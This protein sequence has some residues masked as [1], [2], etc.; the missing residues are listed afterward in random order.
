MLAHFRVVLD[1]QDRSAA[2]AVCVVR[3]P[4]RT[5]VRRRSTAVGVSGTSI[6]KT[7]P[8]PA[9]SAPGSDVQAFAQALDY[10]G[11]RPRP[12]LSWRAVLSTNGTSKIG[13]SS[14]CGMPIRCPDPIRNL[15][16]RWHPTRSLPRWGYFS[17]S[18]SDCGA[19]ARADADRSELTARRG[20]S[21]ARGRPRARENSILPSDGRTA[22]SSACRRFQA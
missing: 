22:H 2:G 5:V 14:D 15:P 11:P 13:F 10:R 16:C 17:A 6:E 3:F 9:A 7:D 4:P 19:F 1:D 20:P 21:A 18:R 8:F 12:W